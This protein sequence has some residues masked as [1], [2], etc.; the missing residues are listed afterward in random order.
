MGAGVFP[1]LKAVVLGW[2]IDKTRSFYSVPLVLGEVWGC[3]EQG[4]PPF[5]SKGFLWFFTPRNRGSER[6]RRQGHPFFCL[7]IE[8][9]LCQLSPTVDSP[10]SLFTKWKQM[11]SVK[12]KPPEL[13][14]PLYLVVKEFIYNWHMIFSSGFKLFP[15]VK[16]NLSVWEWDGF[17]SNQS[18]M[19]SKGR[20][21]VGWVKPGKQQAGHALHYFNWVNGGRQW[22]RE[23]RSTNL[24]WAVV[25]PTPQENLCHSG[26]RKP[27]APMHLPLRS[28]LLDHEI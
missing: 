24:L 4:W 10:S 14:L 12:C 13:W 15:V 17:V 23:K 7:G 22:D 25:V 2:V 28:M 6:V 8:A 18:I 20:G 26:V 1:Q 27:L 11:N 21:W 19:P 3:L 16:R 9:A 5:Q